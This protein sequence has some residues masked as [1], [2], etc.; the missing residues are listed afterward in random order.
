MTSS[1][2]PGFNEAGADCPGIPA[3]N[4]RGYPALNLASMRP[5][6]TAPV[7]PWDSW[8]RRTVFG[9]AS[10]R[11]GQTAPVFRAAIK[12]RSP[13]GRLLQ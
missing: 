13:T 6:Q 5:G 11:P 12:R 1:G 4:R 8:G 9:R 3:N 7:F 2:V 10:M